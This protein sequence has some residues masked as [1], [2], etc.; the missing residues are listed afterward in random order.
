MQLPGNQL[1]THTSGHSPLPFNPGWHTAALS[2]VVI[3]ADCPLVK[4]AHTSRSRELDQQDLS[5]QCKCLQT[6][7]AGRGGSC[8]RMGPACCRTGQ[9]EL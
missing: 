4:R 7:E 8:V 9:L 3:G 5:Q 2:Q 6:E 1:E